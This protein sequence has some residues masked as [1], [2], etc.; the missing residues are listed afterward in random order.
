MLAAFQMQGNTL[1]IASTA[2]AAT[3]AVQGSTLGQ[4][5]AF[6]TNLS[7]VDAYVSI[8]ASS[9]VLASVPTTASPSTGSM[10]LMQRTG[11]VFSVPPQ[12]WVSAITTGGQANIAVTPG[13]GL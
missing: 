10:P 4:Q 6:L 7:T 8:S 5:G 12:C 9:S 3:V 11:K 2:A 13:F 1:L